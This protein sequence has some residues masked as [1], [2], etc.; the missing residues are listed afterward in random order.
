MIICFLDKQSNTH[1]KFKNDRTT[2][3]FYLQNFSALAKSN[4]HISKY[5]I[6]HPP[7]SN[8][9]G[10]KTIVKKIWKIRAASATPPRHKKADASLP[11][12]T[13]PISHLLSFPPTR[14]LRRRRRHRRRLPISPEAYP[15]HRRILDLRAATAT[16]P[17]SGRLL[18]GRTLDPPDTPRPSPP[19]PPSRLTV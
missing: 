3:L 1:F 17:C 12:P 4:L 8:L 15:S 5:P 11:P 16:N 19:P 2:S 9:C 13:I 6:I 14:L 7:R 10:Q 18:L